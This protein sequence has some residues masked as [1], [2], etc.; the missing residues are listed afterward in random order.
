M[1][2]AGTEP[3]RVVL[4]VNMDAEERLAANRPVLP[5]TFSF[6]RVPTEEPGDSIILHAES[7]TEPTSRFTL[8]MKFLPPAQAEEDY[9]RLVAQD[10]KNIS[11]QCPPVTIRLTPSS[12][13]RVP[14]LRGEVAR[15]FDS[16]DQML[17]LAKQ[18]EAVLTGLV[19]GAFLI[20]PDTTHAYVE[21]GKGQWHL[22][23][24]ADPVDFYMAINFSE[25]RGEFFSKG[26]LPLERNPGKVLAYAVA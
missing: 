21:P 2:E 7:H 3:E 24:V 25:K 26:A 6:G 14:R 5:F 18:E 12:H 1:V 17:D 10:P 20:R 16:F 22:L 15:I 9:D 4:A 11:E 23:R 8:A 19:L 13:S